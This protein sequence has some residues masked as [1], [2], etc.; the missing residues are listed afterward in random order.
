MPG[1]SSAIWHQVGQS[2]TAGKN[3]ALSACR[4]VSLVT[5]D[6]N[7]PT[8]RS[9]EFRRCRMETETRWLDGNAAGGLLADVFVG[10]ITT[11][12]ATCA[13]CGRVAAVGATTAYALEMG[14]VLR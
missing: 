10:E 1:G 5:G 3:P 14:L 12:Q 7:R 2:V 13:G 6:G 8:A 4:F 11:A 9:D